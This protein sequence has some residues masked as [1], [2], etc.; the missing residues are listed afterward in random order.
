MFNLA[1]GVGL[2]LVFVAFISEYV[3]STIG[4]GYGTILA[5]VLLIAGFEPLA[6]VPAILLSELLSGL[7]AGAS[8]HVFGNV[9]FSMSS[10]RSIHKRKKFD[11]G[12]KRPRHLSVALVIAGFSAIGVIAAVL[13]AVRLPTIYLKIY[14]GSIVLL[15]GVAVILTRGHTF[16]FTWSKAIALGTLAA[17]N[18]GMSGGGYGPVVTSGQMLAG[19][20]GK[21]AIGITSLAEGLTCAVG[22]VI[23]VLM[24]D[25]IDW[26]LA[27]YLIAGALPSVP[28]SAYTVSRIRTD[29]LRTI[30]GIATTALGTITLLR[31][32]W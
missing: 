12:S 20:E 2:I 28:L 19:I 13:L 7:L 30:V 31:V 15:V 3:D 16:R 5:P 23:F 17:F 21:S 27:P 32:L 22:L 14:I 18:K 11:D 26:T 6:V 25:S 10:N 4:M 24:R 9:N 8:H 29:S 1:I